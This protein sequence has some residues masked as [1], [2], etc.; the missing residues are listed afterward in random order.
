MRDF[1]LYY[2]VFAMSRGVK[3]LQVDDP[4]CVIEF[5]QAEEGQEFN[6]GK[7]PAYP[8]REDVKT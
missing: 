6:A 2:A 7:M 8:G 1:W 3:K 5:W 4:L